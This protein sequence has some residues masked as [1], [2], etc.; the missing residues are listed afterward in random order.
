MIDEEIYTNL[1]SR[2]ETSLQ[3]SLDYEGGIKREGFKI[4]IRVRRLQELNWIEC[5]DILD[6]RK[7][8]SFSQ[9]QRVVL[10]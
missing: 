6:E 3:K 5:G 2:P 1:Y 7:N 9:A 4:L 8:E 10:K